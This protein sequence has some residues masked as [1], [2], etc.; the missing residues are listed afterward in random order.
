MKFSFVNFQFLIIFALAIALLSACAKT[1]DDNTLEGQ[2]QLMQAEYP[3]QTVDKKSEAIYW[4]FQLSLLEI[5]SH[6]VGNGTDGTTLCRYNYTGDSLLI[7]EIY[8][9]YHTSDSLITDA[10]TELLLP[11]GIRGNKAAFAVEQLSGSR[12]V[13]KNQTERLTFR[14][15]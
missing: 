6:Y 8:V 13:L 9:H 11:L 14:K 3:E 15:F 12:M 1:P 7:P 10:S 5:R 4:A 2:W